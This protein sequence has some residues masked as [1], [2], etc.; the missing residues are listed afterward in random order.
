MPAD[1]THTAEVRDNPELERYEVLVDGEVGGFVEYHARPGLVAFVHTEIDDRFGGRG[2]GT[3][4]VA[5][6]LADV[7]RQGLALLPFCPFVNAYLQR[8]PEDVALVPAEYR[9]NFGL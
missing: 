7:R 9:A 4:L 6:A 2:L 3:T 1:A 5:G 8:H